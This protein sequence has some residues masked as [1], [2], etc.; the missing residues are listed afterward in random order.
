MVRLSVSELEATISTMVKSSQTTPDELVKPFW[1]PAHYQFPLKRNP[2]MQHENWREMLHNLI[3]K[4]YQFNNCDGRRS[5]RAKSNGGHAVPRKRHHFERRHSGDS[6]SGSSITNVGRVMNLQAKRIH[7]NEADDGVVSIRMRRDSTGSSAGST[8]SSLSGGA[9]IV[10]L[11]KEAA[12]SGTKR[13]QVCGGLVRATSGGDDTGLRGDISVAEV[14]ATNLGISQKLPNRVFSPIVQ[15]YDVCKVNHPSLMKYTNTIKYRKHEN[16]DAIKR[17]IHVEKC[18][19]MNYFGLDTKSD[20]VM[21]PNEDKAR[22]VSLNAKQYSYKNNLVNCPQVPF[23]SNLGLKLIKDWHNYDNDVIEKRLE[24]IERYLCNSDLPALLT[25]V[26]D[27]FKIV[28]NK[29]SVTRFDHFYIF[30][31][32]KHH[33]RGKLTPKAR[34]FLKKYCKPC[35]VNLKESGDNEIKKY[36]DG[37]K[38]KLTDKFKINVKEDKQKENKTPFK[39]LES[40]VIL[41]PID[42]FKENPSTL[43]KTVNRSNFAL[44]TLAPRNENL[45]ETTNSVQ[46]PAQLVNFINPSVV[47]QPIHELFE[48]TKR[49][50]ILHSAH[51]ISQ[52]P[53]K[54]V[55]TRVNVY[56]PR[57]FSTRLHEVI[58]V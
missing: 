2:K 18:N 46:P 3:L 15:V 58:N 20:N 21:L 54:V 29:N 37:R 9:A 4:C 47:L 27:Q 10:P 40:R 57:R 41:T 51:K 5:K 8:V 33:R 28:N 36:L 43:V 16:C 22:N 6:S 25:P 39:L 45:V 56:N 42:K 31:T 53:Y 38:Q 34:F 32:K 11:Q 19:F 12:M 7:E 24:R 30:P 48:F 14:L 1:W 23:S 44:Q 50:K 13:N 26:K 55:K 35:F 49:G 17:D 52:P